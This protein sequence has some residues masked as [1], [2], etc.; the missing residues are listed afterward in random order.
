[1][2]SDSTQN[3]LAGVLAVFQTPYNEDESIDAATLEREIDWLFACGVD[4]IVLAMVSEVLRLDSNEREY[5]TELACRFARQRGAVVISVGAESARVAE[6]Y[7][8]Q[9]EQAG[10]TALMAI[11]PIAVATG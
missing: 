7:T 10:A 9:A 2:A 4:G 11:P 3:K 8:K 1:M 5:L 6:R